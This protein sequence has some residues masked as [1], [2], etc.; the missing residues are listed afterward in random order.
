MNQ[1]TLKQGSVVK[2]K[3]VST[4]Y[5]PFG[6]VSREITKQTL[7]HRTWKGDYDGNNNK[8]HCI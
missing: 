1:F 7:I 4:Q 8:N 3:N 2:G 6:S 5:E